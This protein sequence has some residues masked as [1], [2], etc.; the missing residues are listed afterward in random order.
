VIEEEN[1]LMVCVVESHL[2][3]SFGVEKNEREKLNN[4]S[5]FLFPSRR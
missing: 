1:I 3:D 4:D 2:D 5:H